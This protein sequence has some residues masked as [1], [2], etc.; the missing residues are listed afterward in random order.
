MATAFIATI[1]LFL[2]FLIGFYI[3]TGDKK[4]NEEYDDVDFW[5]TPGKAPGYADQS[6]IYE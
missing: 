2:G 1:T 3:K 4:A 5:K 6:D